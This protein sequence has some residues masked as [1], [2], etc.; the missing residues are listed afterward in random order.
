MSAP[1]RN[2]YSYLSAEYTLAKDQWRDVDI[3][4]FHHASHTYNVQRM[5]GAAKDSLDYFTKAF[6]PYQY[7]QLRIV[8]FP[9]Y[10]RFAQSF[11]GTIPYSEGIGF[12][13]DVTDDDIDAPY[14]VTAHEVSHQWWGHQLTAANVQGDGF[15]HE[16]LAQ[17]SALL[18]MEQKY[19]P[20]QTRRLLKFE[21]D[22]YLESRADD[23]AGE[24][25]L[26]K[27]EKQQHI[28]YRKGALIMYALRDYVGEDIVNETLRKLLELRSYS[29][30]PYATS[31]DFLDILKDE[32]GPEH[33]S[34]IDDLFQKITLYDLKLEGSRIN[35]L[36][37]GQF[38][39]TLNISTSKLYSDEAGNETIV[40]F[41]IPVYIGL[42]FTDPDGP[43]FNAEKVVFLEKRIVANGS[44]S[45]EII[46]DRRPEFAGIDP[47]NKLIDRTSDD[48]IRQ[49]LATKPF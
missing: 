31:L 36:Q 43:N 38:L 8:E 10:R 32:A 28:H 9:D 1:S 40:P 27:V 22:R 19:G 42:F 39:V 16:T 30:T 46:T 49:V 44:S 26:Y 21:L 3:E 7:K 13:A 4:V 5:I 34:L 35:P 6:S 29:S 37:N 11:P 18:V 25:P 47:Y 45:I 15:I 2:G 23:P 24:Q 48:N 33:R 14:Y 12:V 17:Y 20:H 41:D